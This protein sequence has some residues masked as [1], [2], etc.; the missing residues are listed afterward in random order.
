MALDELYL[1][2]AEVQDAT[3]VVCPAQLLRFG[4]FDVVDRP[5]ADNRYDPDRGWRVNAASGA[6]TCVHPYRVGLPAGLYATAG[7]SLPE[8]PTPLRTPDAQDLVLP[9]DP[10]LL[11][12]WLIAVLRTSTQGRMASALAEAETIASRRFASR[13]VVAAMRRVMSHELPRL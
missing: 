4:A 11:E 1:P 12:A 8:V 13:D 3:C 10:T 2:P 6:P 7:V 9:D 5:G